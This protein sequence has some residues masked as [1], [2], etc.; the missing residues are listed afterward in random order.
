[1]PKSSS[2]SSLEQTNNWPRLKG[3][4]EWSKNP[5]TTSRGATPSGVTLVDNSNICGGAKVVYKNDYDEIWLA[6]SYID[7]GTHSG[8]KATVDCPEYEYYIEPIDCPDLEVKADADYIIECNGGWEDAQCGGVAKK[9]VTLE[10][11]ECVEIN[12]MVYNNQYD[13]RP[14][15]MRCEVNGV[16]EK[17]SL[18]LAFDGKAQSFTGSWNWNGPISIGTIRAGNEFGGILCLTALNGATEVKCTGPSL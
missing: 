3:K 10:L 13:Q 1:V 12:V 4:C 18:T 5:T 15:V 17:V 16:T 14:L 8:I 9:T 11:D 6:N 7:E 2:S